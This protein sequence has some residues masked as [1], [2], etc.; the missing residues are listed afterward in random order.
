[1]IDGGIKLKAQELIFD[2]IVDFLR[3][4]GVKLKDFHEVPF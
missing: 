3:S 1:V 4:K 2:E